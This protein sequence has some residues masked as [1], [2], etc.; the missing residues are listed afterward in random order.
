[1]R[2]ANCAITSA[3]SVCPTAT[4]EPQPDPDRPRVLQHLVVCPEDADRHR[5][6]RERDRE[7]LKGAERPLQLRLVA[8]SFFDPLIAGAGFATTA[9]SSPLPWGRAPIRRNPCFRCGS[10]RYRLARFVRDH[11]H[12]GLRLDGVLERGDLPRDLPLSPAS[13]TDNASALN[14]PTPEC[15]EVAQVPK[16]ELEFFDPTRSL[17]ALWRVSPAFGSGYLPKIRRRGY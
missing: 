9:I 12:V 3:T 7:H 4:I 8:A 2:A 17:G 13:L 14:R 16:P 6:E 10:P 15:A 5:D 1:M 11:A